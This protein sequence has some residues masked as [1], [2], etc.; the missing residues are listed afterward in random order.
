MEKHVLSI[1]RFPGILKDSK[2]QK[3]PGH[4][5]GFFVGIKVEI[6]TE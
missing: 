5:P 2:P 1:G 3:N 6:Y 4:W